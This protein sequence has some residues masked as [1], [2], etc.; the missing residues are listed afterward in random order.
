M[1]HARVYEVAP[2]APTE[3]EQLELALSLCRLYGAPHDLNLWRAIDYVVNQRNLRII[4]LEG[5]LSSAHSPHLPFQSV[6][7]SSDKSSTAVVPPDTDT[8]TFC[9]R[10]DG[11]SPA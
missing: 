7:S 9:P 6:V 8:F 1:G 4:E 3:R 11:R 5:R 2:H 10:S